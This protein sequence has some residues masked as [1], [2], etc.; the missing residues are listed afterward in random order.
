MAPFLA[1]TYYEKEARTR[2]FVTEY[3]Q[4]RNHGVGTWKGLRE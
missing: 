1:E 2:M 3:F 4:M